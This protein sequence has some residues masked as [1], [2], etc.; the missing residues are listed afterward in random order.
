MLAFEQ[1]TFQEHDFTVQVPNNTNNQTLNKSG[2]LFLA[3]TAS[4]FLSIDAVP[5]AYLEMDYP[6]SL[7]AYI[8]GFEDSTGFRVKKSWLETVNGHSCFVMTFVKGY[9]DGVRYTI[10]GKGELLTLTYTKNHDG[11]PPDC[12]FDAIVFFQSFRFMNPW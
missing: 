6:N 12:D 9:Q 8:N 3:G 11:H 5:G 7:R 10:N 4:G 2:T 1:L